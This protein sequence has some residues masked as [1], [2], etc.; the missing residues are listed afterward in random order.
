MGSTEQTM[1][2]NG[3]EQKAFEVALQIL[4]PLG[5]RIERRD[6]FTLTLSNNQRYLNTHQN[7]LLGISR[8]SFSLRP[9]VLRVRNIL[10]ALTPSR[11]ICT[12]S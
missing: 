9:G 12:S 10:G 1:R 2:F 6:E 4:L 3:D 11:N 7:A 5:F 8:V